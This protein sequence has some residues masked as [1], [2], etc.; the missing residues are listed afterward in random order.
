MNVKINSFI[1]ITS[2]TPKFKRVDLN[3]RLLIFKL[4]SLKTYTSETELFSKIN[5]DKT[6]TNI[7]YTLHKF[8]K[9]I[10]E[11]KYFQTNFRLAD[12]SNLIQNL[13]T[14]NL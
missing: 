12:F 9:N 2:R 10:N 3:E 6:M 14:D 7:V 5:R 8:I 1:A 11:Y 4:E 13:D